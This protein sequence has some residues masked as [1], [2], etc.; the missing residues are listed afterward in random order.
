M[1]GKE[2]GKKLGKLGMLGKLGIR[3]HKAPAKRALCG[4]GQERRGFAS[5]LWYTACARFSA[6]GDLSALS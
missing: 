4:V 1:L 2:L 6:I 5:P 3:N